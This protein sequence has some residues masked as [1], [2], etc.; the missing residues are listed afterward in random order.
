MS[1][2]S[3]ALRGTFARRSTPLPSGR[4]TALTDKFLLDKQ[5][6]EQWRELLSRSM[7]PADT[8]T[9]HDAGESIALFLMP[10]LDSIHAD[11]AA[12]VL[13]WSSKEHWH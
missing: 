12:E 9:L 7:L 3:R 10:V 5:K 4:P 1:R 13:T 11:N 2:L 6:M 8:G